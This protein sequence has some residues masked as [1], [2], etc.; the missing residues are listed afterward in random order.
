MSQGI[1]FHLHYLLIALTIVCSCNLCYS[2]ANRYAVLK[3]GFGLPFG[4]YG[5]NLEY[6]L[7]HFGGYVGAGYMKTQF[8]REI[9]IPSSF[10]G[11]VGL[12]YYFLRFEDPWHPIIGIHAGWLNNYYH[13]DIGTASYSYSVYGLALIGGIELTED[14]V[15]LEM[16]MVVDP[17]FAILHPEKHPYYQGKVYFTPTIG[18][19]V[20]LYA[21]HHYYKYR[22]KN[23]KRKEELDNDN[24]QISDTDNKQVNSKN[25]NDV[26]IDKIKSECN[27]TLSFPAVRILVADNYGNL[28]AGKQ[29]A[30]DSYLF[31]RFSSEKN[32]SGIL[33]QV[34]Q[35]DSSITDVS[36]F[37][38]KTAKPNQTLVNLAYLLASD[39]QTE[40]NT[41]DAVKGTVSIYYYKNARNEISIKLN[42]LKLVG[43]TE[44]GKAEL[45][46]DEIFI[47]LVAEK[48]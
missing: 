9:N 3:A 13:K 45:Y 43:K 32:S 42:D 15:S 44:T 35:L 1:K 11:A 39:G 16:S 41:F 2:Q 38:I 26:F 6:R 7:Y 4:A 12:K 19:G 37:I 21:I 47:C 40:G 8:Y 20:N 22:E 48:K 46:Y 5:I 27:D 28:I 23:R 14:V 33:A 29:I 24:D 36:V 17:S 34:Y 10:N 18:I 30:E 31:V 25:E